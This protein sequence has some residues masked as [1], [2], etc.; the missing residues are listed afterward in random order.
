[1]ADLKEKGKTKVKSTACVVGLLC[2][3]LG[4]APPVQAGREEGDDPDPPVCWSS[5]VTARG[6][7]RRQW[8][9]CVSPRA[10][11]VPANPRRLPCSYCYVWGNVSCNFGIV[12]VLFGKFWFL[13]TLLTCKYWWENSKRSVCL[14]VFLFKL[15]NYKN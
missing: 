12:K 11:S 4:D 13:F 3:W 9:W 8:R 1:M 15:L 10:A 2:R 14:F 6:F 7:T 5:P